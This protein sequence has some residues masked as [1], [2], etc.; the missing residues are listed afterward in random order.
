MLESV[1]PVVFCSYDVKLE[2][3]SCRVFLRPEDWRTLTARLPG[4]G[5]RSADEEEAVGRGGR[6]AP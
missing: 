6:T 2:W 3:Q 1:V 5:P 4:G